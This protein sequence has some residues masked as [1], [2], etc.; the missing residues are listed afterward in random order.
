MNN[1][2]AEIALSI[3]VLLTGL[4]ASALLWRSINKKSN[5]PDKRLAVVY[6][7]GL[8]GAAVGA[9][10]AFLFA[11]GPHYHDQLV[12]LLTGRSI[13]GGLL[14]GY[15]MVEISKHMMGIK[16]TTGDAF[17]LVVPLALAFG[18]VGCIIRGCCAGVECNKHWWTIADGQGVNRWPSQPIEFAFNAVMFAWALLATR[19]GWLSG[20]RFHVYLIAYGL[21]RFAHEFMRSNHRFADPI[22]GY[23]ILAL[24]VVLLGIIRLWNRRG[25]KAIQTHDEALK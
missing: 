5:K 23:H 17:A 18:R 21:F 25:C 4:C 3:A 12:P 11:E 8:G 6:L 13:L 19:K 7:A 22:G 20:N 1:S 24:A 2:P 14:G 9:K 16:R 10:L 15:A